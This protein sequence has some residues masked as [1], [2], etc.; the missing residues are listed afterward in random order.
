MV[1][2]YITVVWYINI[3]LQENFYFSNTSTDLVMK[4]LLST[5]ESSDLLR[6]RTPVPRNKKYCMQ[7][8]GFCL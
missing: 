7:T 5:F 3:V 8:K 2:E 4:I 1:F 6:N